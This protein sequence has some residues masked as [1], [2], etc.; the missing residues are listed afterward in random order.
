MTVAEYIVDE[1]VKY[2]VTD[3]FGIPGG[4]ILRLLYAMDDQKAKLTPHLNYH[5]QMAGFAACGYS[6]ASGKLGV[7]Y[8][9]RG[10]GITNMVSSIAEAYQEFLP[11][12]FITAHGYR[13]ESKSPFKD[14]QELN[15]I[16]ATSEITKYGANVEHLNDVAVELKRACHHALIGR[17]GPVILDFSTQL[18]GQEMPKTYMPEI[19]FKKNAPIS[20]VEK[21]VEKIRQLLILAQ[22]PLVL[23]GDGLRT[24]ACSVYNIEKLGCPIISSRASQDLVCQS[25]LY[26]GYIGSHGLRYSNF[27]LSK[28]DLIIIIGNRMAFPLESKSFEPI[29][30]NKHLIRIEIDEN[31]LARNIPNSSH[32]IADAADFIHE[33]NNNLDFFKV[34]PDWIDV[35]NI[36]KTHLDSYD[37]SFPVKQLILFLKCLQKEYLYV[38]DIGNNEFW[39]ARAYEAVRPKG[40]I[41]YS[42]A[43]GTLGV[44]LGRAIGAYYATS[45]DVM[46]IIGDQGFQYNIQELQFIS[47]WNL[48]IGII[49]LN[50]SSSGM[51]SDHEQR[52]SDS[53]LV[54]VTEKTGYT[55]PDF[56]KII[57]AYEIDYITTYN[58]WL[59]K[60]NDIEKNGIKKPFVYEIIFDPSIKL[61]PN[62]PK[63]N[64]CPSMTP[65]LEDKLYK[66]LEQL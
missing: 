28:S 18:L 52:L 51:I 42:K 31:E 45:K 50:N 22:R 39:F 12:L 15:I 4:V 34:K 7:A 3:T 21:A 47:Y 36:L 1:L 16:N 17:K 44:A 32:F 58:G 37:I 20:E 48:P 49:L 35:C 11:V 60:S 5:E 54:H 63:E 33:L 13:A 53:R 38:C 64:S 9:T 57:Q 41:L 23:I 46:C 55:T 66:W 26:Y 30:K 43:Y 27:I 29:I 40:H 8:A 25:P 62:L 24:C 10:P 65:L 19:S 61:E 14:N 59:K 56:K 6:Q 2:G